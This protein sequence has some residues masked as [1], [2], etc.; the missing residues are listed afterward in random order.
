MTTP[1]D[2]LIARLDSH[3][4]M[5]APHHRER[6]AGKLLIDARATL[7]AQAE[8]HAV[9]VERYKSTMIA[10]AEE[11]HA[12][13]DAHCDAE[14]YGPQNLQRRL[15]E[16]IPAGYGYTAGAFAALTAE[17]DVL[18]ADH[19]SIIRGYEREADRLSAENMTL[20]AERDALQRELDV[21]RPLAVARTGG[22]A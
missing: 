3:I 1:T 7:A 18:R 4:R 9:E 19:A 12:H 15:E 14:G 11:I 22:K 6:E 2:A 8:A 20:R 5:M 17:R 13:W 21:L 10:A 16:G